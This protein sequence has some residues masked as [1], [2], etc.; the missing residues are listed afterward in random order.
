MLSAD[1]GHEKMKRIHSILILIFVATCVHAADTPAVRGV[2]RDDLPPM[3]V[4]EFNVWRWGFEINEPDLYRLDLRFFIGTNELM[5]TWQFVENTNRVQQFVIAIDFLKDTD[6]NQW[7]LY[8]AFLNQSSCWKRTIPIPKE[9]VG[10]KRSMGGGPIPMADGQ[11]EL[12]SFRKRDPEKRL[13][14]SVSLELTKKKEE[15][16]QPEN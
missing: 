4:G 11:Y 8:S 15:I 9:T 10:M 14:L 6:A 1:V 12:V 13:S 16:A 7:R 3:D 5:H 2:K